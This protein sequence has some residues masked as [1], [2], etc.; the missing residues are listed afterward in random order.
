M[1]KWILIPAV[2]L[3]LAIQLKAQIDTVRLN[4]HYLKKY[5]TDTRDLTIS[6]LKWDKK[7]W[8]HFGMFTA[9]T[10]T[11][12]LVDRSASDF[13]R[14]NRS[15]SMDNITESFFDP[16]AS[17]YS[18][19]LGG[20][21]YAYGLAG[22]DKKAQST[23][24]LVVES[25]LVGGL[26][27]NLGKYAFGRSRPNREAA[28]PSFRWNGPFNGR[29]F[30]SGHTTTAFAVAAVFANQYRDTKW[31]PVAAYTLA[32]AAG[33]S[34]VYENRH[35]L[36]DTFAGAVLGTLAGN[37]ICRAQSLEN[38]SFEPA[39]YDGVASVNFVLRF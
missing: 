25:Y 34:R 30:P 1:L 13:C 14:E 4:G 33:L 31:V 15:A 32:T 26:F 27:A 8:L 11:L 18:L 24:L 19:A 39:L 7:D 6:P 28:S 12:F 37:Y 16:L 9:T 20:V 38:V 17:K 21:F 35:W 2:F 23:G 22:K 36:S 10:A 3:I 29:S 5:W